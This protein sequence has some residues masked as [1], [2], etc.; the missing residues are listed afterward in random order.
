MRTP[1][2]LDRCCYCPNKFHVYTPVQHLSQAPGA[3]LMQVGEAGEREDV[4]QSIQASRRAVSLKN[5]SFV[6]FNIILN[7][8]IA[9][10]TCQRRL[11]YPVKQQ[12]NQWSAIRQF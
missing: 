9:P 10:G 2:A 7:K 3:A 11:K 1:R 5:L 12:K 8:L 4:V 6:R